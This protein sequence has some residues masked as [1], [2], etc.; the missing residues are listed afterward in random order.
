VPGA[1]LNT[2][3]CGGTSTVAAVLSAPDVSTSS[4]AAGQTAY[5]RHSA[6]CA[7]VL[8]RN[9][10]V[11]GSVITCGSN[12]VPALSRQVA[13]APW[14]SAAGS[15]VGCMDAP[16]AC[17]PPR[18]TPTVPPRKTLGA[19]SNTAYPG[20]HLQ[21]P[22]GQSAT[23]MRTSACSSSATL[24][25]SSAAAAASTAAAPQG[26]SDEQQAVNSTVYCPKGNALDIQ[27]TQLGAQ[28]GTQCAVKCA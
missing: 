27:C 19:A 15:M 20:Q 9:T 24:T 5:E 26:S 17:P 13:A 11:E 25:C 14:Y 10:A 6:V 22:A 1:A 28:A 12:Q 21:C 8:V 2:S 16:A 23:L 3:R 7:P 4:A 18:A